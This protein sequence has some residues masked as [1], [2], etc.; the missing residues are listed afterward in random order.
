MEYPYFNNKTFSVN[1]Q[2]KHLQVLNELYPD[3]CETTEPDKNARFIFENM[4]QK[5]DSNLK[6]KKSAE[7]AKKIAHLE[8][9]IINLNQVIAKFESAE[10][11]IKGNM[12]AANKEIE[13][14]RANLL[15]NAGKEPLKITEYKEKDLTPSQILIDFEPLELAVIT[16]VSSQET[17][18][19]KKP[20]TPESLL[21]AIFNRYITHGACDFFPIPSNEQLETIRLKFV[22][23]A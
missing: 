15:E 23:P 14:L 2:D 9:E 16:F 11:D 18:R 17:A 5:F 13:L 4:L 3:I 22:K 12:T 8:Q 21:K 1:M 19:T 20:V 6:P 7:D 10:A